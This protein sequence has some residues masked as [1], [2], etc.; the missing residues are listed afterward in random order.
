MPIYHHRRREHTLTMLTKEHQRPVK[1]LNVIIYSISV[2][3][4]LICI[5]SNSNFFTS[6]KPKNFFVKFQKY[7]F[8]FWGSPTSSFLYINRKKAHEQ[9]DRNP[10]IVNVNIP[11]D[12]AAPVVTFHSHP[13]PEFLLQSALPILQLQLSSTWGQIE[14]KRESLLY[15]EILTLMFICL[16]FN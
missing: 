4:A 6:C 13:L 8:G 5:F 1:V 12:S 2:S 15:W 11:S 16:H 3:V 10:C 7:F 9:L 14:I